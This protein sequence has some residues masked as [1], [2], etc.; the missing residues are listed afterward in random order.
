MA[1]N[2][3]KQKKGNQNSGNN[4]SMDNKNPSTQGK[5]EQ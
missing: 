5:K 2:K 3:D 4:T 1:K